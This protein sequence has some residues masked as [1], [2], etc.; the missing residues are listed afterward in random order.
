M[1]ASP[2]FEDCA[3]RAS[4]R[5]VPVRDVQAAAMQAYLDS[6]QEHTSHER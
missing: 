1:N 3:A 4:E 5:Q 2:E 6:H